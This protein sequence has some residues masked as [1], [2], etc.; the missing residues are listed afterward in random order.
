M[1]SPV[2][3]ALEEPES[4]LRELKREI[5][6]AG[7]KRR[8][9]HLKRELHERPEDAPHSEFAFGRVSSAGLNHLD[10]D[11]TRRKRREFDLN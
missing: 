8:R 1:P 9:Q 7:N 5:K 10:N 3:S 4:R 11:A 6:R 2:D